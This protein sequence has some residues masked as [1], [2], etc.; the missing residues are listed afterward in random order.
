VRLHYIKR[1]TGEP[2]LL[3]HGNGTLI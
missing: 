2:L 3:I 1:G